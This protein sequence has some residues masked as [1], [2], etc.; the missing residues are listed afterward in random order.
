MHIVLSCL[1]TLTRL[2]V[3]A[4]G[5][6][7]VVRRLAEITTW[8]W[9]YGVEGIVA[10]V[11]LKSDPQKLKISNNFFNTTAWQNYL[12]TGPLALLPLWDGYASIVWSV[13]SA[14]AKRLKS[15]NDEEFLA[16]LNGALRAVPKSDQILSS[17][18]PTGGSQIL[19]FLRK[20]LNSVSN[21]IMAST[22]LMDPFVLPPEIKC[23]CSKRISFPLSFQQAKEYVKPRVALIGDA[24]HSIH[25]QAGQGLNLGLADA[26][27]LSSI[28]EKAMSS[29][30][31]YGTSKVLERYAKERYIKNLMMLSVVDSINTIF[32]DKFSSFGYSDTSPSSPVVK[33]KKLFR[34]LG[35][36]G[37]HSLGPLKHEIAKYAMGLK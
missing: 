31:D 17:S 14:V 10:T 24:A 15:L 23:I 21:T 36:L 8:G 26:A 33:G 28:I 25:P 32:Q 22:H 29:G 18:D 3:G 12:S 4:D 34:S 19:S 7:S 11:S 2:L 16:E 37:V 35:M 5:S 9:N 27:C 13:P 1:K 20:E 30:E 6:Q